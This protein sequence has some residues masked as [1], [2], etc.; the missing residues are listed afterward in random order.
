MTDQTQ[1]SGGAQ[2]GTPA[3]PNAGA[4]QGVSD[5]TSEQVTVTRAEFDSLLKVVKRLEGEERGLKD[6]SVNQVKERINKLEESVNPLLERA[7]ELMKDGKTP[8]Q[9]IAEANSEYDDDEAMEQLRDFANFW[10]TSG[11]QLLERGGGNSAGN[12]VNAAKVF[13]KILGQDNLKNPLMAPFLAKQYKD[14]AEAE[15]E[16]YRVFYQLSSLPNPNKAQEASLQGGRSGGT[17][18]AQQAEEKSVQL[19]L[20]YDNYSKNQPQIESLEKE[21]DAHWQNNRG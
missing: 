12:G 7:A 2:G 4:S 6:K 3:Q 20:L 13:E 8:Q 18:S 5:S 16:A 9:A 17:L 21:L 19:A 14:N 10:K 11:R 15:T 1:E